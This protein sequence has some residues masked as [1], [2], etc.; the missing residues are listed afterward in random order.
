MDFGEIWEEHKKFIMAVGAALLVFFIATR[1]V[2]SMYFGPA[3]RLDL[4]ADRMER[5]LRRAEAPTSRDIKDARDLGEELEAKL[6]ALEDRVRFEVRPQ[7]RVPA[8]A[9]HDLVFNQRYRETRDALLDL[10]GIMD[11]DLDPSI[12]MPETTPEVR[13]S[14]ER[15][16]AAMDQ[17]DR[18]LR[19]AMSPEGSSSDAP[20]PIVLGVPA[21]RVLEESRRGFLAS[22]QYLSRVRVE[23]EIVGSA[24]SVFRT[25]EG[26][27]TG[28]WFAAIADARIALE[29]ASQ[30]RVRAEIEV[31]T[32]STNPDAPPAEEVESGRKGRRR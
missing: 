12:G 18:V 28:D 16:L 7:F 9:D 23:Y 11:V 19:L 5:K 13:V 26:I 25:I 10:A 2:N 6:A 20:L 4:S 27:Q 24:D 21:I 22:Q 8:G 31:V 15:H 32:L 14:V 1:I 17:I 30:N 29:G 3:K